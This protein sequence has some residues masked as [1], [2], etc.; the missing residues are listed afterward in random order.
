MPDGLQTLQQG[1]SQV[2]CRDAGQFETVVCARELDRLLWNFYIESF[3]RP[4][5]TTGFFGGE[6]TYKPNVNRIDDIVERADLAAEV[7][8][9]PPADFGQASRE[10]AGELAELLDRSTPRP[11]LLVDVFTAL[12]Q[13][14]SVAQFDAGEVGAAVLRLNAA[15]RNRMRVL[16]GTALATRIPSG[17]QARYWTAIHGGLL[18]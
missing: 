7:L 12:F 5:G 15:Q 6:P 2:G 17:A 4:G 3:L 10:L 8:L 18:R 14:Q 16:I 1:L 13:G 9:N 11:G